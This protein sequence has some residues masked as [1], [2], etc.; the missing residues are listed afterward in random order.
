MLHWISLAGIPLASLWWLRQRRDE[1]EDAIIVLSSIGLKKGQLRNGLLLGIGAGLLLSATQ[2][3]GRQR[4]T[5]LEL[6][7]AGK[8]RYL[9]PLTFMLILLTAASTE[10]IFFRGI[11]QTRL[12]DLLRSNFWAIVASSILFG[13]YHVLYAYLSPHWP[14]VGNWSKALW[15]A[16]ET[17]A[18]MG[19]ALG[20]L[21]AVSR[22]NLLAPIV[23]HALINTLPGM[24]L[25]D[26]FIKARF[27]GR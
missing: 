7:H 24:V 8:A 4:N 10:E 26:G 22:R 15:Y 27:A 9:L 3:L 20:T 2:L 13:L 14:S 21:Y 12:S 18:P 25:L 16:M 17:G 6:M 19:L 1:K 11:L 5:K 23:V